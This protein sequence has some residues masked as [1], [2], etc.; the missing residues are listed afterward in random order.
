MHHPDAQ[1]PNEAISR[2]ELHVRHL[3]VMLD[4]TSDVMRILRECNTA[5][6]S[7]N[8]TI[9]WLLCFTTSAMKGGLTISAFG[10]IGLNVSLF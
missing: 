8:A 10:Q 3:P 4:Y 9:C 7:N 6:V 5:R 2:F 1:T